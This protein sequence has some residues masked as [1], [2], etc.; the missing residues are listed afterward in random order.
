[1]RTSPICI[2]PIKI[3]S[4]LLLVL[5]LAILSAGCN[6]DAPTTAPEKDTSQDETVSSPVPTDTQPA[7]PTDTPLP[8][9]TPVP[10]DTLLPTDTPT[11]DLESTAA[12]EATAAAE[13]AI[14]M[15]AVDL[16]KVG[17]SMDSGSL[18]WA[19]SEPVTINM[20]TYEQE[21]FRPLAEGLSADNFVLKSEVTWDSTSGLLD[22]GFIFRSEDNLEDGMNYRYEM[23]RLSGL[24]AWWIV[25][26][27]D[28]YMEKDV[29]NFRTSREINQDAGAM[30]KVIIIAE[31]DR[32]TLY[33]ND[34]RI[35]SFYD[36]G[37]SR[38][39]GIFGFYAYHESGQSTC[40]FDNTWIWGLNPSE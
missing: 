16:E 7:P 26:Y 13:E 2:K 14:A 36:Y 19:Q 25:L 37:K 20:D 30:N 1:M 21:E 3:L 29:T 24:P 35:G 9:A 28:N 33:I 39:E 5:I 38:L 23:W 22:C 17:L 12:A 18:L 10:T 4:I 31:V 15:V 27:D 34:E 32:F 40:T 11:P 8:T 6:G